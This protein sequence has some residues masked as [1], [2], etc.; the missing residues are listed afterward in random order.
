MRKVV[1]LGNGEAPSL[2]RKGFHV[3]RFIFLI[4]ILKKNS[5]VQEFFFCFFFSAFHCAEQTRGE[6]GGDLGRTTV[7]YGSDLVGVDLFWCGN[8]K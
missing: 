8:S 5:F 6:G 3:R 2:R 4:S 1:V 7:R